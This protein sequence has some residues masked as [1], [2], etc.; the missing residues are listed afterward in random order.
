MEISKE[1]LQKIV[2]GAKSSNIDKYLP[3]INKL[4]ATYGINTTLRMQHF[5]AQIAHE[6]GSFNY[7]EEIA[8]GKAYEGR[9][10]LG[11]THPGDGVKFKGRGLIQITGELNYTTLSKVFGVDL[12]KN[13]ELLEQPEYAVRSAMWYWLNHGLSPLA[14]RDDIKSITKRING[15][16]NGL[17]SRQ[18]FLNKAK[19]YIK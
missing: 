9:K 6:S 12:I 7:V 3:W 17:A 15:G 10:D 14:D 11:N 5:I 13:P 2:T 19:L 18:A 1:T 16:L 8:S 4:A